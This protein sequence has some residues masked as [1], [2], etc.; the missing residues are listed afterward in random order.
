MEGPRFERQVVAEAAAAAQEAG[1]LDARERPPKIRPGQSDGG[2][3]RD[4][5]AVIRPK[6]QDPVSAK[7]TCG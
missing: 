3:D 4:R 5:H 2:S 7:S 6:Q 1:I